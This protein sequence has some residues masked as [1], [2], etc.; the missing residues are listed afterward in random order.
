MV[1]RHHFRRVFNP[2]LGGIAQG[3]ETKQ[4]ISGRHNLKLHCTEIGKVADDR[5][6]APMRKC[7][8]RQPLSQRLGQ[9]Q[10]FQA[11]A[12][13]LILTA[14]I[15]IWGL[16]QFKTALDKIASPK[17]AVPYLHQQIQRMPPVAPFR[18]ES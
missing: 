10:I 18:R 12:P 1:G 17:L 3:L 5:G 11:W 15:L 9:R 2:R 8:R 14:F 13:W 4:F 7:P 6:P 16:P